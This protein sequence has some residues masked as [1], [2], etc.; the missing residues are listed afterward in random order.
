MRVT[1]RIGD[2]ESCTEVDIRK[3]ME[4]KRGVDKTS[5]GRRWLLLTLV[6]MELAHHPDFLSTFEQRNT[7]TSDDF[8]H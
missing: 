3:L 8:T 2:A 1:A 6:R 7:Q 5:A 4:F